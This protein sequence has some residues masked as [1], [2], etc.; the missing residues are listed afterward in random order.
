MH[1][2]LCKMNRND[3]RLCYTEYLSLTLSEKKKLE[4]EHIIL[5][6]KESKQG[7]IKVF[8][9]KIEDKYHK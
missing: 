9:N 5:Y 4:N 8:K 6:M 2:L 1:I 3:L 7:R